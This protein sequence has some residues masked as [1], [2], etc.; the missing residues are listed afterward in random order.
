MA[1]LK[2]RF[3]D[4]QVLKGSALSSVQPPLDRPLPRF[5][6]DSRGLVPGDLHLFRDI[7]DRRDLEPQDRHRLKQRGEPSAWLCPMHVGLANS[8]L[9]AVNPGDTSLDHGD[10][11]HR[12]RGVSTFAVD[13]RGWG[14]PDHILDT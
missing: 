12:Y 9:Q 3:I 5:Q 7:F 8:V 2:R 11:P 10:I 6:R 13:D 4:R 14:T 1:L